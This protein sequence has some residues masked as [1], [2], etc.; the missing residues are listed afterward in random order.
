MKLRRLY[1]SIILAALLWLVSFAAGPASARIQVS[2]DISPNF[3]GLGSV[4]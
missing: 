3:F 1:G 4:S 2:V